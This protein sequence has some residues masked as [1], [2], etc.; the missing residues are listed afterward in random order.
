MQISDNI[1]SIE[2]SLRNYFDGEKIKLVKEFKQIQ[3]ESK[4]WEVSPLNSEEQS[5]KIDPLLTDY[6]YKLKETYGTAPE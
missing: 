5:Y 4:G 2:S 3:L 6:A 1:R